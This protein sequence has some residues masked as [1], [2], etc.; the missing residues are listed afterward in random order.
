MGKSEVESDMDA[1][2]ASHYRSYLLRIWQ[3]REDHEI[4]RA[5]LERV[6]SDERRNFASLQALFDYLEITTQNP[7]GAEE[8]SVDE[9]DHKI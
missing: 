2:E 8:G 1:L 5:S 4:W 7:L 3:V 6:G 9:E